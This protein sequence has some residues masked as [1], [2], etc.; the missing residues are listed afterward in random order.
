MKDRIPVYPGRIQLVPSAAGDDLFVLARADEPT[1]EGTPLNKASLLSDATAAAIGLTGDNPTVNDAL[2][3]LAGNYSRTLS[4]A[5]VPGYGT[6]AKRGDIY[7]QDAGG[8]RRYI[9]VCDA[10]GEK[11]VD[12][13]AVW[14]RG[15]LVAS[16]ITYTE[17]THRVV[18]DIFML[19]AGTKLSIASGFKYGIRFCDADRNYT[20][21]VAGRTTDWTATTDSLA[22]IIIN[23]VTEDTSEVADVDEFVSALTATANGS[24]WT[25]VGAAREVQKEIVFTASGVFTVPAD[26]RGNVTVRAFGGGAGGSTSEHGYGGGGGHMAVWTGPLT[27]K[28]Y[29]VTVGAGGSAGADGGASSFGSLV[30]ANGGSGRDGGSG[31]GGGVDDKPGGNGSYGGGGGACGNGGGAGGNGGTYGG[32]GGGSS[33]AGGSGKS[34]SYAGGSVYNSGSTYRGGGGAGYT[35]AGKN[36][37]SSAGGAGGAGQ[38]TTGF[39]LPFEGTGMAGTNAGGGGGFGGNGGNGSVYSTAGTTGGGGGGYGANGGS[40]T[41]NGGGGGGGYGGRGGNGAQAGGGGGGGYG[42]SGNGG[43]AGRP[44]G[45]AAGGGCGAA[46]GSGVVVITYTGVEVI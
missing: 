45:I 31:G 11:P 5:A 38:N 9:Y 12:L 23:R 21:N 39:S 6:T 16:S 36:A 22:R 46:G 33:G 34:G 2:G 15:S 29:N 35:A 20:G 8:G 13:G 4:G 30:T 10:V 3:F 44:G 43:D 37:T 17:A 32:G 1:Q 28:R 14:E 25:A 26:L 18:S 24:F 7:V 40:G 27:L 42:L 41:S 19:R